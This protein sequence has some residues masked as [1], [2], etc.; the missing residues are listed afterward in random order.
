MKILRDL[1]YKAPIV[2]II[3]TTNIAIFNINFDSRKVQKNDVFVAIR[4][5][6]SNGHQYIDA[7]I[8]N[9]AIAIVCEEFP[10]TITE[11][12]TYVKVKDSNMA[13]AYI[14]ANFYDNP[15]EKITLVGI[16]GT[17][18]KTT[19][20]TLLF[21]L[22]RALGRKVGLLSTV[23]NQINDAVLPATHTTPD[24]IQLN[25]LLNQ[26]VDEGCT[27][28]FMEV[29]S[30]ALIQHRVT[31]QKFKVA[32]FSNLTHDHLDYHKTFQ[33]Y[34]DA[35]KLL[36]DNL[37]A[38]AIA[39]IN[40]DDKNGMVMVQNTKA[41]ILTFS[42]QHVSDFKIKLLENHFTGML[43]T[44]DG[45]EVW[46]KLIGAFNAYN[47][48][49]VY[50][51]ATQLGEDKQDVLAALSNLESVAGRFQHIRST[52]G[53]TAIVDYAHTPDALENVLSTI[54]EIRGGNE[55]VITIIGCGGDRDKTKRPIMAQIAA[56]KSN[57]IILT[58]DNPRTE[59]PEDILNE[60]QAG[61]DPVQLKKML[62]IADRKEAIRTA[63]MM[64][65][66][67]DIILLAGKGHENYQEINGVKNHFDDMETIT[68]LL[69]V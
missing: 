57:K 67:D 18:G 12:I 6:V 1:L 30:H 48:L 7:C 43:V 52:A 13:L 47:L 29:S 19:T 40:N 28:A 42:Q 39:L 27:H 3:G 58:S 62:R 26:M 63:V 21:N 2:E 11:G 33:S 56:D 31:A 65:Q 36:F 59:N 68:Q 69:N 34:R 23:K 55:Q 66:K 50:A 22:Y 17:N 46:T 37:S 4:G 32:L 53:I 9:G 35:K 14:A 54:S 41:K 61:L 51:V 38:D 16:T 49:A 64:A 5:E 24:A 8:T 25:K 44:I 60:M 20:V 10:T 15:S 45:V